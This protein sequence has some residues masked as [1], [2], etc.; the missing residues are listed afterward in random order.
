M[1]RIQAVLVLLVFS[2]RAF[3]QEKEL[4]LDLNEDEKKEEQKKKEEPQ[5]AD[6]SAKPVAASV[7]QTAN[8]SPPTLGERDIIQEDRVKSVQRKVYLKKHRFELAPSV[9]TSVNDP[10]YS[11]YALNIRGAYY[12]ADTLALAGRFSWMGVFGSSVYPSDDARTAKRDFQS[13]IFYSVPQWSTMGDVEW[14]PLYGKVAIFNSILH[15]DAYILGGAGVVQTDTSAQ[16]GLNPAV[17]LGVGMRFVAKD[18][19]AVNVALI[20]TAYVD[21]PAGTTKGAIQNLMMLGAGVSVFLP[22][23]STGREAE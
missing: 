16:R 6:K 20:N 11:K 7:E 10:Y 15:I 8:K 3:G 1:I 5:K 22:F 17:D 18:F 12:L 9:S 4:G 23:Q 2:G 13:R 21:Q 14:S 19:L